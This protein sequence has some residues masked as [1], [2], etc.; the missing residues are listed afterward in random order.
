MSDTATQEAAPVAANARAGA[1]AADIDRVFDRLLAEKAKGDSAELA[2]R[3]IRQNQKLGD[4]LREAESKAAAAESKAATLEGKVADLEPLRTRLADAEARA[5]DLES[6]LK[7][8]AVPEG[9]V[10]IPKADAEALAAFKAL[11]IDPAKVRESLDRLPALEGEIARRD[12]EKEL[13]AVAA[14]LKY[15]PSVL[16]KLADG[17]TFAPIRVKL[18]GREVDTF[19]V[20]DTGEDGKERRR[21]IS[22]VE[23]AEWKTWLPALR[24]EPVAE[25]R[26]IP[27]GGSPYR[28][29]AR[30]VAPE[31]NRAVSAAS[32]RDLDREQKLYNEVAKIAII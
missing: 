32:R 8:S 12:R 20:V 19:E 2:K 25:A 23:A 21:P 28:G 16:N 1:S 24:P 31:G 14:T 17:L 15:E 7:A 10:P 3:L 13:G 11:G 18:H 6:R 9:H 27:V 30:H 22:D 4:Q 5:L 26:S 29:T